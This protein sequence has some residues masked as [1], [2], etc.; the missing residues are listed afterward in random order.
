[1]ATTFGFASTADEGQFGDSNAMERIMQLK[2]IQRRSGSVLP[3]TMGPA[4]SACVRCWHADRRAMGCAR[5]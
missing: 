1:M 4:S 3:P 2:R 5:D